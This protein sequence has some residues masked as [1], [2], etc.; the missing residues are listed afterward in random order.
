MIGEG[1]NLGVTQ[2]G[3][4]EA[5]Q[6]GV[7]LNTDAIDNSAGVNTSDVEV[8]IKIA[9][10]RPEREG[11]LSPADRNSLLAAMTDEVGALVLRNNYLQT[12]ALSLAERKGVAETGFLAPPDAVA[13]AARLA[14]TARWSS[15]P[16]T[17]RSPS[18]HGAASS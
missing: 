11:R 15:C 5:A 18:A 3:R 8:N 16:T 2:R 14:Q 6:K 12:L 7:K 4:I 17:R 10:A 13:R 9:L 1:A